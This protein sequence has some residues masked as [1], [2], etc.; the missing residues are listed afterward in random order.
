MDQINNVEAIE[1]YL[2]K[3]DSIIKKKG[4]EI[5]KEYNITGPQFNALQ[6]LIKEGDLTIASTLLI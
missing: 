5:L 4:R 1:K 6:Y 3:V 2:R